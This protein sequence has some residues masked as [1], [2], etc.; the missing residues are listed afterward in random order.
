MQ[1]PDVAEAG[2]FGEP[3][4]RL[5]QRNG[6]AQGQHLGDRQVDDEGLQTDAVLQRPGHGLGKPPPDPAFLDLGVDAALDDLEDDVVRRSRSTASTPSAPQASTATVSSTTVF[7]RL[8]PVCRFGF[9]PL[10][11]APL[12]RGPGRLELLARRPSPSSGLAASIA[13]RSPGG[14]FRYPA[15][16]LMRRR[17]RAVPPGIAGRVHPPGLEVEPH[18]LGADPGRHLHGDA[19]PVPQQVIVQRREVA[20]D[21]RLTRLPQF[22]EFDMV[23][24]GAVVAVP[25]ARPAG[26]LQGSL[27]TSSVPRNARP[28]GTRGRSRGSVPPDSR[29]RTRPALPVDPDRAR[30]LA[31]HHR[32]ASEMRF[33]IQI[34]RGL[35]PRKQ[36]AQPARRLRSKVARW[37]SPS[38]SMITTERIGLQ[39]QISTKTRSLLY[40]D[41]KPEPGGG[42]YARRTTSW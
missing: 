27:Q 17:V 1:A 5:H 30:R 39:C 36:L 34:M 10:P 14:I 41:I 12:R 7:R 3:G 6:P 32:A 13:W 8:S 4:D 2:G 42:S 26:R 15:L 23:G 11:L 21:H 16:R 40:P 20:R 38:F 19:A 24:F 22:K 35:E 31:L 37:W 25:P 9:G 18:H 29:T 28:P 33:Y